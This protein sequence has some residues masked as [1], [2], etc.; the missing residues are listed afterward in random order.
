MKNLGA[1]I[2]NQ[3]SSNS[4]VRE[5]ALGNRDTYRR[6]VGDIE[7]FIRQIFNKHVTFTQQLYSFPIDT[8]YSLAEERGYSHEVENFLEEFINFYGAA[9]ASNDI[10][11]YSITSDHRVSHIMSRYK[12]FPTID[13]DEFK[14][15]FVFRCMTRIK[16]M[17]ILM[18]PER[19]QVVDML[20]ES[21][22]NNQQDITEFVENAE[23]L[24]KSLIYR[25]A[26]FDKY[27][28][29][30]TELHEQYSKNMLSMWNDYLEQ[31]YELDE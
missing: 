27:L 26:E 20:L 8:L 30:V 22:T 23:E 21:L 19:S 11:I 16:Y 10:S 18:L 12:E 14:T 5:L 6:I 15:E 28:D 29:I 9:L 13:F 2:S 24:Q 7:G 17:D 3:F 1:R 25:V 4:D 31:I